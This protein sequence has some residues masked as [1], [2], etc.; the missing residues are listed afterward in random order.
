MDYKPLGMLCSAWT[1]SNMAVP[2]MTHKGTHYLGS[3]LICRHVKVHSE[4]CIR[5]N[6]F[7]YIVRKAS[8]QLKVVPLFKIIV[9]N[10]SYYI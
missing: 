10:V 9:G 5:I 4:C 1:L 8:D 2:L 6:G 3:S 7:L